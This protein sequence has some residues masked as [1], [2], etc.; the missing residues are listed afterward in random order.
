MGFDTSPV[1]VNELDEV[2]AIEEGFKKAYSGDLKGTV[3]AVDKLK[4]FALQLIPLDAD[5]E[6]ELDIKALVISIGDIARVSAEMKMEQACSVSGRVLGDISLEA[7]GQ[8]RETIAIKALS[9]VGSLALEFAG[10]GLDAAAISAA[11]SLGTCGKG[12]SI[13]KMETLISLAEA[14]LLQISLL[15]IE[16]SLNKTGIAAISYLGEIGVASAKQAIETSTLEAS[17]I[18][19]DLGN[20]AVREN[21]ESC[22]KAVIEA[23]EN[24]GTE[25]SQGGMKNILVQIAWSLE[26]IRL[27]AL[28][29]GMKGACFA[30]KAALE[31]IN[32]AGL[33]DAEQNLEKIR[34]IKEFHSFILKKS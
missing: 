25:V 1:D 9:I 11:E 31:S 5:A 19:E 10:K 32:T 20:A 7:A 26:M 13:M 28:E 34:E 30:A 21:N 16:K 4:G 8:K 23:L 27:L 12:Y 24:L 3:E 14:Y 29:Q 33:L 2:R 18:L 22:T 6:N 17:V 15:S